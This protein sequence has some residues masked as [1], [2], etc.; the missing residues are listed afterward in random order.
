MQHSQDNVS[1]PE[2]ARPNPSW[3]PPPPPPQVPKPEPEQE[4][5]QPPPPKVPKPEPEQEITPPPP[6]KKPKT[7]LEQELRQS[8]PPPPPPPDWL[9]QLEKDKEAAATPTVRLA[10]KQPQR[11]A[12]QIVDSDSSE[13]RSPPR[14]P[15]PGNVP[16][17]KHMPRPAAEPPAPRPAAEPP[18]EDHDSAQG[19]N[20][21]GSD[22]SQG[23][24][25]VVGSDYNGSTSCKGSPTL[26]PTPP[27]ATEDAY[28]PADQ[29]P[30]AAAA[31][32][33]PDKGPAD[34]SGGDSDDEAMKVI[35]GA[36]HFL[37]EWHEMWREMARSRQN[38]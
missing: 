1:N 13:S 30:A 19:D 38:R 36:R 26:T 14:Q 29:G 10:T 6:P 12:A 2:A 15:L 21:A 23:S 32:A 8:L 16:L 33:E 5:T 27:V 20:G 25:T 4:I 35:F 7:E 11:P 9:I 28:L 22:N 37:D 18:A 24:V 17:P 3:P 34:E 31:E